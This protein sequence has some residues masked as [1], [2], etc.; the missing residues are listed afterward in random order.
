MGMIDQLAGKQTGQGGK[1][2]FALSLEDRAKLE[3]NDRG[4]AARILAAFGDAFRTSFRTWV[5][6]TDACAFEVAETVLGHRISG[7]VERSYAR[8]D[9]LERRRVIMEKWAGFVTQPPSD[10]VTIGKNSFS[11]HPSS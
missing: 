4:N 11:C 7:T 3:L 5:Q 6:D 9:L 2:P 8:S 1:N 10:V